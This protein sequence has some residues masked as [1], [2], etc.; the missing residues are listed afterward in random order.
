VIQRRTTRAPLAMGSFAPILGTG[1]AAP[2]QRWCPR[3]GARL[4]RYALQSE[5]YCAPCAAVLHPWTPR[6]A[7]EAPESR[8][9]AYWH[10]NKNTTCTCGAYKSAGSR[11]CVK[12]YLERIGKHH[13]A[14]WGPVCQCGGPKHAEARMCKYCRYPSLRAGT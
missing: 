2:G 9:A 1:Y 10:A 6:P 5:V 14:H 7:Y 3:C 8:R 13:P 12:C 4:S 11:S